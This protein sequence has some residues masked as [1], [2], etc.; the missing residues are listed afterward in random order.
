MKKSDG[1]NDKMKSAL[2]NTG[3]DVESMPIVP[4]KVWRKDSSYELGTY[5]LLDGCSQEM[6]ILKFWTKYLE[7]TTEI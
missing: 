7:Q 1:K 6:F 3:S 4:V 2:I 5:E